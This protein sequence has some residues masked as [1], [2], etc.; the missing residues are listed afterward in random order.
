[1]HSIAY[2]IFYVR[3]F[4]GRCVLNPRSVSQSPKREMFRIDFHEIH[5]TDT[6]RLLRS[7]AVGPW[8]YTA[9]AMPVAR[10]HLQSTAVLNTR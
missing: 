6:D 10:V 5:V 7:S 2:V 8:P 3:K 1:M 4:W 9:V